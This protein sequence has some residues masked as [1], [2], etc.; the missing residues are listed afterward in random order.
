MV[1]D[2]VGSDVF[3]GESIGKTLNWCKS[4]AWEGSKI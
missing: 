1:K 3:W 4:M 2:E